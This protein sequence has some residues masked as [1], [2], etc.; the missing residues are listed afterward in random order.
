MAVIPSLKMLDS[1]DKSASLL[2]LFQGDAPAEK[3]APVLKNIA[4]TLGDGLFI[5][6]VN[7]VQ[8]AL[9]LP[10]WADVAERCNLLTPAP[11]EGEERTLL[12]IKP[13]N[14]RAPSTR[15]GAIID[16]LMSIDLKWVGC[17]V[18]GMSIDE[19]LE[20]YSFVSFRHFYELS[21]LLLM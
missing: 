2:L 18:H 9:M 3:L 10:F 4:E 16:M 20:F 8:N 13:E 21:L 6:P 7:D 1:G 19:A 12:I 17:K 11:G 15:P 5:A 14:F